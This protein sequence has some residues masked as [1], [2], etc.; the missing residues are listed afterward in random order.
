MIIKLSNNRLKN[1]IIFKKLDVRLTI[2]VLS[3]FIFQVQR[4]MFWFSIN[5]FLIFFF[6]KKIVYE[7]NK[8]V[9]N[10]NV[11]CDGTLFGRKCYFFNIFVC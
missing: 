2:T 6:L 8:F 7:K 9:S 5:G 1:I 11:F 3:H 10:N 4:K